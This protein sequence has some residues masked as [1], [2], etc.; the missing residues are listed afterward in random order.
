[1]RNQWLFK[2]TSAF[3]IVMLAL[4][5]LPVTPSYAAT[6]TVNITTDENANN[7]NCSLREA[8]IAANTDLAYNGCPAGDVGADTIILASGSTYTLSIVGTGE[9]ASAT[10]DLDILDPLTIQANGATPAIIN[11]TVGDDRVFDMRDGLTTLTLNTITV[12]GGWI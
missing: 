11:Q 10:G 9:N 2:V 1:M 5:A 12:S 6:I 8:V 4:A 3:L 7:G